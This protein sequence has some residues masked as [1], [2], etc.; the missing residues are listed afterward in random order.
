M[1]GVLREKNFKV[2]RNTTSAGKRRFRQCLLNKKTVL[3]IC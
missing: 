2:D 1:I 3:A